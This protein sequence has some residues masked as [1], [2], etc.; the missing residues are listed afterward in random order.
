MGVTAHHVIVVTAQNRVQADTAREAAKTFCG[1]KLVSQTHV[2]PCNGHASFAVFPDGSNEHWDPSD[3][4]DISRDKFV[5][6]LN[7][8][9]YGDGGSCYEWFEAA[10]GEVGAAGISEAEDDGVVVTRHRWQ[11]P[12]GDEYTGPAK[13]EDAQREELR[14]LK[15][16]RF[17]EH[18][19]ENPY[20]CLCPIWC[21]CRDVMC[22][23]KD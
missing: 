22:R 19:N 10:Y 5:E 3:E 14:R 1:K 11:V 23:D 6:W 4:G 12:E 18:P 7:S 21:E 8:M 15:G 9:R 16:W 13:L 20:R 2:A 17:C